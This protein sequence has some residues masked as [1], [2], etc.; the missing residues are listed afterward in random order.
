LSNG[1]AYTFTVVATNLGGDSSPSTPSASLTPQKTSQTITFAAIT[2]KVYGA[3]S[4]SVSASSNSGLT[5]ALSSTDTAVCTLSGTTVTIVSTGTC[6]I[7][8]DQVG[9]ASYLPATTVSRTFTI[10]PKPITMSVAIANK[11]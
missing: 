1:T 11:N 7:E 4:F 9:D 2:D 10:T 8:A 3:S 6:E 5:V